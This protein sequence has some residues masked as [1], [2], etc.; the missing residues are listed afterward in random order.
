[1]RAEKLAKWAEDHGHRRVRIIKRE[2][3]VRPVRDRQGRPYK[4]FA[5]GEVAFIDLISF[6][7]RWVGHAQS[8]WD[9]NSGQ[10]QPWEELFPGG[11]FVMRL[12]KGDTLQLFDWDDDESETVAGSNA[13]KRIVRLVPGNDR[14]FLC[15][16]NDAGK[17]QQRHEDE[18][19]DF[20]WD[21][22]G[23]DKLRLRRARRVRIDELG[24][25]HTIPH[26]KV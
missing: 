21:W 25:V 7:G 13:V 15:G 10:Q 24:R 23:F 19:D 3:S 14:I 16:L 20:R 22:P 18:G 2:N 5:P 12:H 4:F 17:L 8:V 1:M 9:A 6:Q 11:R 26:G